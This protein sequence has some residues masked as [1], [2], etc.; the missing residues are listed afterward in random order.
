MFS[1]SDD[2]FVQLPPYPAKKFMLATE[3]C[4]NLFRQFSG[5]AIPF[6]RQEFGYVIARQLRLGDE[7]HYPISLS[8]EDLYASEIL[9]NEV[10]DR[11]AVRLAVNRDGLAAGT[12]F[13]AN[14]LYQPPAW[15]RCHVVRINRAEGMIKVQLIIQWYLMTGPLAGRKFTQT[16]SPKFA[17]GVYRALVGRNRGTAFSS[18]LALLDLQGALEL[19]FQ[20]GSFNVKR[21]SVSKSQRAGNVKV[22]RGRNRKYAECHHGLIVDCDMCRVGRNECHKSLRQEET[23]LLRSRNSERKT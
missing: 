2:D 4:R 8:I 18:P 22:V 11:C 7:A 1:E 13:P 17:S 15:Q 6:T 12:A 23:T 19:E 9:T 10:I 5:K 16:I 20:S 21:I 14:P 3:N